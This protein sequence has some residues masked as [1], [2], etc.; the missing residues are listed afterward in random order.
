METSHCS[1]EEI[2]INHDSLSCSTPRNSFF[3]SSNS[4]NNI[5]ETEIDFSAETLEGIEP[6]DETFIKSKSVGGGFTCCVPQCYN[7]SKRDKD[8]SFYVI[9]KDKELRK[10]WLSMISRKNFIPTTAH[11]VCSAHFKDGNKTYMNNVP[12]VVPKIVKPTPIKERMSRNSLGIK[13]KLPSPTKILEYEPTNE[14]KLEKEMERLTK[15][16]LDMESD[17]GPISTQ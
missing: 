9:P 5:D 17:S 15:K 7:N 13:R 11:R 1:Q 2:N 16:I 12:T 6:L 10:I 3:K 4:S 14:E 8:L